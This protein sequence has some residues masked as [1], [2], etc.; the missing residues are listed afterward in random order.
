MERTIEDETITVK[1]LVEA[2]QRRYKFLTHEEA[3]LK[4]YQVVGDIRTH[5]EPKYHVGDVCVDAN[6]QVF[7]RTYAN[8]WLRFGYSEQVPDSYPERPLRRLVAETVLDTIG[9]HDKSDEKLREY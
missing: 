9:L 6:G 7:W 8:S 2:L 5:R 3:T 1:E 4:A